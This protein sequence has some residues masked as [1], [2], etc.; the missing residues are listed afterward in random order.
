MILSQVSYL[1]SSDSSLLLSTLSSNWIPFSYQLILPLQ[2]QVQ[3]QLSSIIHSLCK[4][5]SIFLS[6]YTSSTT[7]GTVTASSLLL[8]TLSSNWIPFSYQ[9]ILPLQLQ[10]QL[11][12]STIIHSLLKLDSIFLSTYTSSTTTGTVT[13]LFYYSLSSQTGFHFLINLYFLYNWYSYSSLLLST[14]SANWIPFSFQLILPLQLQG[15][16]VNKS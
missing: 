1:A 7:T 9:L 13:A 12:L 5:D 4:L 8:S 15:Q 2:L 6:T 14:P 11:Q 3:L 10:V 16:R